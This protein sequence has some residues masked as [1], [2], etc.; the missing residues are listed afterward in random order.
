MVVLDGYGGYVPLYRIECS[1]VAA[2]YGASAS[3]ETAVPGRD[4]N[5]VTMACEAAETALDR[6]GVDGSD[7]DA[8]FVS[9]T[10]DPFSEHGIAGPVAY[11]FGATGDVRTGDFGRTIRAA[12]DALIAARD[13]VTANGGSALVVGVDVVP[14]SYGDDEEATAGAGA[15]AVVLR[16]DADT[17]AATIASIGQSTTG[18]VERHRL[19]GGSAESGDPKFEGH[20]QFEETVSPALDRATAA[21]DAPPS[22]L[23]LTRPNS[24]TSR[25]ISRQY[26]AEQVS[27]FNDVGFASTASFFLDFAHLLETAQSDESVLAVV[28]GAGG[29]DAIVFEMGSGVG[30]EVGLTVAEGI[31]SKEYVTYAE[32]HDHRDRVD[33]Q[34]VKLP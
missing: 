34:G 20:Y 1:A 14:A 11:R 8:V 31:E 18:F 5:H 16:S 32:H 27:T 13:H 6:S 29:A 4:E 30:T 15:G 21:V 10:T 25:S 26:A 28:A 9:S 33:Y 12:T 19:Q 22:R 17:P 24:R 2:Q 23:V 3:G 7:P